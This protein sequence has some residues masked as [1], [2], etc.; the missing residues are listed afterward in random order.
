M[1][2]SSGKKYGVAIRIERVAKFIADKK[3]RTDWS[4]SW[5]GPATI[6]RAEAPPPAG[7]RRDLC[8]NWSA[9]LRAT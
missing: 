1:S 9:R 7:S 4:T 8:W 2:C 6:V 5:S 3:T